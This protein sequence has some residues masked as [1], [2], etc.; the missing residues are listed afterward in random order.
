MDMD[1]SENMLCPAD[2]VSESL[3]PNTCVSIKSGT[4]LPFTLFSNIEAVLDANDFVEGLLTETAMSVIYGESNCGKTFLA[5]DLALH[6]ASG[7]TWYGREVTQGSVLYLALEGG[8]GIHNRLT[9]YRD[10]HNLDDSDVAF[11]LVSQGLNLRNQQGDLAATVATAK[12]I[13]R[14]FRMPLRLIVIDTLSRAMAGG[15]ENAPEDMTSLVDAGDRLRQATGAHVM[16]IHHS[17]KDQARGA[18]GHSSLRAA[19]DTEI[20]VLADEDGLR[21]EVRKQRD[22]VSGD[23]FHF[24]REVV[25]LGN[26]PRGKPV[27]SCVIRAADKGSPSLQDPARTTKGHTRRAYEVLCNII[28]AEGQYDLVGVP[29]RIASVPEQLWRDKFYGATR[30]GDKQDTKQKAFNRATKELF[31]RHLVATSSGRV[32][33]TS[34]VQPGQNSQT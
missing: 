8:I 6:V 1:T 7:T 11:A 18:R 4:V 20:E 26:N 12:A 3:V 21:A 14:H 9:A 31:T 19:T 10:A 25:E 17:G 28:A 29:E 33:L 30:H 32:W 16:W 2:G 24:T 5:L 34:R 27:T 13:E 23:V 22:L 15:N